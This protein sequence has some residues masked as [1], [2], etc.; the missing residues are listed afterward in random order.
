M[1]KGAALILLFKF[2]KLSVDLFQGGVDEHL[3]P[4]PEN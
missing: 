1:Q 2:N 4:T 3:I